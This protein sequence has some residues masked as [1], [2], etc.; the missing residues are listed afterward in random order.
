M[1]NQSWD[2]AE[3]AAFAEMWE[4]DVAKKY[5][6]KLK[7]GRDSFLNAAM[8]ATEANDIICNTKIAAGMDLILQDIQ[9]G[10]DTANANKREEEEAKRKK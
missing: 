10:T 3:I 4:S 9:T 7:N 5:L 8:S 2:K 1:N 6:D